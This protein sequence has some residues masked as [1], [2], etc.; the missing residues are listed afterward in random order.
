MIHDY[1][2]NNREGDHICYFSDLSK[3]KKHYP[4]WSIT[5]S[6]KDIFQ[7]IYKGWIERKK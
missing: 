5:K 7:E 1:V 4:D 2:N 6:L 3:I